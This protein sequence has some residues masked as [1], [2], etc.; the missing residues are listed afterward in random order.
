MDFL[1]KHY[2]KI[3]LGIVLVGL[4]GAVVFMLFYIS[5]EQQRLTE[6]SD[7]VTH[8]RVKELTNL[9]MTLSEQ[10][11]KRVATRVS[12]DFGPPNRLFNPGAWQKTADNRLIPRENVGPAALTVTNIQPLWFRLSLESV[13]AVEGG[14]KYVIGIEN[15]ADPIPAHR[16]KKTTYC[17]LNEKTDM[18]TI[19]EVHGKPEDPSELVLMLKD[20][21]DKVVVKKDKPY[22]RVDGYSADLAYPL[23][24]KTWPTRRVG[25]L[26]PFNGEEYN[27]VAINKT[28]VVLAAKSNGKKWTI[29]A[30]STDT[31]PN[32]DRAT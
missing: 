8:P 29:K 6:M 22:E 25:A 4:A 3:V 9:D 14:Y 23:E 31:K 7:S 13:E 17:K 26:L 5:N 1:K 18:F 24:N 28:E 20:S 12:L 11:L 16:Y 19:T 30:A 10:A 2:E 32:P 27:V 15:Q 21:G